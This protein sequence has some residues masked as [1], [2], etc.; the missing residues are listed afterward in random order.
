MRIKPPRR[1]IDDLDEPDFPNPVV[2]RVLARDARGA[3]VT[4]VA[5]AGVGLLAL[6][7]WGALAARLLGASP[8]VARAAFALVGVLVLAGATLAAAR[9]LRLRSSCSDPACDGAPGPDDALCPC[10]GAEIVGTV[11]RARD[12]LAAEEWYRVRL[13]RSRAAARRRVLH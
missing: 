3:V 13:V 1:L 11:S 2:F 8:A 5:A 10:C 12:R 4:F 6:G 9:H 7:G